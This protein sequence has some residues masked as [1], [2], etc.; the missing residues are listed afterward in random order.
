MTGDGIA[1]PSAAHGRRAIPRPGLAPCNGASSERTM[2]WTGSRAGRL[3]DAM[4]K[5]AMPL[6]AASAAA[7]ST[8]SPSR[9][10]MESEIP[11]LVDELGPISGRAEIGSARP[12]SSDAPARLASRSQGAAHLPGRVNSPARSA[13]RRVKPLCAIPSQ[14]SF[15]PQ[16]LV[17]HFSVLD[18]F[19][20]SLPAAHF[21]V[22]RF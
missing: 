4:Q 8:L 2:R 5:P 17:T 1:L 16:P 13:F 22:L 6:P 15:A 14:L 18:A 19:L 20:P 7:S 21:R 12:K 3:F 9:G 11:T 10:A